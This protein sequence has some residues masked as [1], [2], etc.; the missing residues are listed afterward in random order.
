MHGEIDAAL[1]RDR[2]AAPSQARSTGTFARE[3]EPARFGLRDG[4]AQRQRAV[5]V[6]AGERQ[7]GG[8]RAVSTVR[9]L[10]ARREGDAPAPPPCRVTLTVPVGCVPAQSS[11]A[12]PAE[13]AEVD[14][15]PVQRRVGRPARARA[16]RDGD[17]LGSRR[18]SSS[19]STESVPPVERE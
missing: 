4:A 17:A 8:R 14:V 1:A 18:A 16:A 6:V 15:R 11:A 3:V 19:R 12:Q 2:A 7:R 5:A 9:P 10:G 13:R